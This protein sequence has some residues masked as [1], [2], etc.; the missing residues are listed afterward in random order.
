[1]WKPSDYIISR[2]FCDRATQAAEVERLRRRAGAE[3]VIVFVCRSP[4]VF[5]SLTLVAHADRARGQDLEDRLT[6]LHLGPS[7]VPWPEADERGEFGAL[8]KKWDG[9]RLLQ[10]LQD[11]FP[12][13]RLAHLTPVMPAAR[14]RGRR[15]GVPPAALVA[16]LVWPEGKDGRLPDKAWDRFYPMTVADPAVMA[17]LWSQ[18]VSTLDRELDL[19]VDEALQKYDRNASPRAED[20]QVLAPVQLDKVLK[21]GALAFLRAALKLTGSTVGQL[22]L[23]GWSTRH[24]W[25]AAQEGSKLPE[26]FPLPDPGGQP[27]DGYPS[28]VQYVYQR[29]KHIL[30]N[31]VRNFRASS[32]RVRYL[33]P[34]AGADMTAELAV[35]ITCSTPA[36]ST[37]SCWA[38]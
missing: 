20:E 27:A 26:D 8:L 21:E 32:R 23:R 4:L 30:I 6:Q 28:V 19:L 15:R 5:Q 9:N 37:T 14:W 12:A 18:Q 7:P 31:N 33:N 2:D 10:G 3:A 17:H 22:F 25:V 36:A 1:M 35:P 38:S 29:N 11:E 16:L 34:Y 13:K 24:L